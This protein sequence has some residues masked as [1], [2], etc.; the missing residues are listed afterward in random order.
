MTHRYLPVIVAS[1]A[2]LYG[3]TALA[4][5]QR[6]GGGNAN[7]QLMQQLQQLGS[8]RTALQAENARMKKELAEITKERDALKSG[9]TALEQRARASEASIARS[10]QDKESAESENTKLKERMQELVARF[11]ET[12][13]TLRDV[14]TERSAFK[15]SLATRDAELNQCIDRNVAL[16][17]LNGEVLTRLEKRGTFS[18]PF[19]KIK[20]VQLENL[21]D[22]YKYRAEEQKTNPPSA[23]PPTASSAERK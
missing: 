9:K 10:A 5:T 19:T 7:A 15:Q 22:D 3:S 4:Q 16:Y 14:E 2:A 11:R 8:E 21:I 6:S 20:R 18:D 12:A 13:T 1:L 17:Q 23:P